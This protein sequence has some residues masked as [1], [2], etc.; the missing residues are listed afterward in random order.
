MQ[1][2]LLVSSLLHAAIIMAAVVVL[3]APELFKVEKTTSLPVDILTIAEFTKLKARSEPQKKPV[4]KTKPK[5]KPVLKAKPEP[6]PAPEPKPKPAP[7]PPKAAVPP[8]KPEPEPAPKPKPK[9]E[10][11]PEPKPKPKTVKKKQVETA[12][13]PVPRRK[14]K[15]PRR[16]LKKPE[17]RFNPDQIAALLNKAP[18]AAPEPE[19]KPA[20]PSTEGVPE[21]I[22]MKLTLSELDALRLQISQC[23]SPPIGVENAQNLQIRLK[24]KLKRDGSLAGPP[25][26]ANSSSDPLFEVA[27]ESAI[28]A[29]IR[30]QSYSLPPEKYETWR[31]VHVTFDPREMFGR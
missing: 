2:G 11:K 24:L 16:K 18:D 19:R 23:W 10:P 1:L 29:V 27:A 5:P 22:D 12:S 4:L 8:P 28:R 15:P 3:P 31:D 30:C 20:E 9:P 13:V 7:A 17:P 25:V 14:P 26:L 21:G 6:K